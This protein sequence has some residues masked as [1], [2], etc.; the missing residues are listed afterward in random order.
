MSLPLA[1]AA[2]PSGLDGGAMHL[3]NLVRRHGALTR[4]QMNEQTGWAR[5]TVTGRLDQLLASG[6]LVPD[7][8]E[9]NGRGRPVTRFRIAAERA[10]LIVADV[11]ALGARLT[12]CDLV[13]TVEET[14]ER[15]CAIGAAPTSYC[16]WSARRW[17]NWPPTSET[18]PSG[19]WASASPA[20]WSSGPDAWSPRRS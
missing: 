6:L 14:I 11:G 4:A 12:R 17:R 1:P 19:A 8:P 2:S 18:G 10:A 3:L 9:P 5:M 16:P 13:G 15:E 7:D 20:R